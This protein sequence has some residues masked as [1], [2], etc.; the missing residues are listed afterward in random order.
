M[1]I[2]QKVLLDMIGELTDAL[3]RHRTLGNWGALSSR[4]GAIAGAGAA[5]LSGGATSAVGRILGK[6]AGVVGLGGAAH[7]ASGGHAGDPER[8][9][10]NLMDDAHR[11]FL[12]LERKKRQLRREYNELQCDVTFEPRP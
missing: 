6:V 9:I 3:Y 8:A 12:A 11:E 5:I 1:S 4:I 10:K 2:S 7:G